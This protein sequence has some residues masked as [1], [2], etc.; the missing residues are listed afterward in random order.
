MAANEGGVVVL[1]EYTEGATRLREAQPSLPVYIIINM[2]KL[3]LAHGTRHFSMVCCPQDTL[4][5]SRRYPEEQNIH[6]VLCLEGRRLPQG[7]TCGDMGHGLHSLPTPTTTFVPGS[8]SARIEGCIY[9][10][11]PLETEV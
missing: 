8:A 7:M 11:P 2:G 6:N 9:P 10:R 4:R 1:G 5:D 3:R